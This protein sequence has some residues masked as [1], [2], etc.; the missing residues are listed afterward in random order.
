M[1]VQE[2]ME[3]A[4]DSLG[5]RAVFGDPYEKNG[6]TVIAAAQFMGGLGGGEGQAPNDGDR[7]TGEAS[8]TGT[9]SGAGFGA[10]GKPSGAFVI[11]GD[12]VKW[13][14]AVDVNRMLLGFQVALVVFF[15]SIRSIVRSR[16]RTAADA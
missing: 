8:T 1:Q 10:T 4:K 16:A 3:K 5:A 13:V 11:K 12:D 2:L 9:G 15:I 6:V 7:A 14:P